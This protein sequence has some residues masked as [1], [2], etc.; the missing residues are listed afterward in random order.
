MGNTEAMAMA[1][2][3]GAK[4]KGAEVSVLT[5]GEFSAAQMSAFDAVAFGCPAMGAEQL[6]ESEFEPMFSDCEGG[7]F[8][9]RIS[10]CLVLMAGATVNGC[11]T[12]SL[13]ATKMEPIW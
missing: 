10:L 6:E 3:E 11:A 8:A 1:V 7:G 13:D 5:A 2:A 4:N 12:G 9:E